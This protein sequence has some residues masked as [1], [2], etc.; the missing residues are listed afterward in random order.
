MVLN[1]VVSGP[2]VPFNPRA[3]EIRLNETILVLRGQPLVSFV[4]DR[5]GLQRF[6]LP[7]HALRFLT[8]VSRH[9]V[10]VGSY[11]AVESQL[12]P[13][14]LLCQLLH[15]HFH[16]ALHRGLGHVGQ[17]DETLGLE[18]LPAGIADVL[19]QAALLV[20]VNVLPVVLDTTDLLEL[21]LVLLAQFKLV[22]RLAKHTVRCHLH[23]LVRVV[24]RVG[25]VHLVGGR[26]RVLGLH[27]FGAESDRTPNATLLLAP[28]RALRNQALTLALACQLRVETDT[29]SC[30]LASCLH[31]AAIQFQ[32]ERQ[33]VDL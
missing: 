32:M 12:L 4:F 26:R 33:S 3:I 30:C 8:M 6:D 10:V 13:L 19:L 24:E 20:G 23:R 16:A 28:A 22:E 14:L 21:V 15:V 31:G 9:V 7:E 27:L 2:S 1:G 25:L 18:T 5:T 17:R 29:G 11:R